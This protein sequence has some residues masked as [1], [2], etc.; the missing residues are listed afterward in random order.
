MGLLGG[1]LALEDSPPIAWN[2]F[3]SRSFLQP[4]WYTPCIGG[5]GIESVAC[6][7][8]A[9]WARQGPEDRRNGMTLSAM[10]MIREEN[11]LRQ[12]LPFTCPITLQGRKMMKQMHR[13][14]PILPKVTQLESKEASLNSG[15][16][17]TDSSGQHTA[18]RDQISSS[19]PLSWSELQDSEDPEE[20][21]RNLKQAYSFAPKSSGSFLHSWSYSNRILLVRSLTN[22][23]FQ[24]FLLT[25]QGGRCKKMWGM[26]LRYHRAHPR[27][28]LKETLWY[29]CLL[30]PSQKSTPSRPRMGQKLEWTGFK[31]V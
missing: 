21:K 7:R 13:E 1:G 12:Q 18:L 10:P 9:E 29:W 25:T 30:S 5:H 11:P 6:P 16:P 22:L 2:V 4:G 19:P 31:K 3:S 8:K 27:S 23:V 14:L 15:L 26:E 17:G 24:M 28:V 20:R